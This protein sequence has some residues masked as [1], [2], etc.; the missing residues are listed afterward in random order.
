M[1]LLQTVKKESEKAGLY[2][3]LKKRQILATEKIDVFILGEDH[4]E[5]VESFN[6]LGYKIE[7]SG[8]HRGEI[9]R[10]SLWGEQ[11]QD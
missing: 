3:N 8:E 7:V 9:N 11:R 2:L 4:V 5:I 10:C 1:K 6:F